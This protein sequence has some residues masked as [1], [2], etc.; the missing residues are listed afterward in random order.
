LLLLVACSESSKEQEPQDTEQGVP[1][2][3]Q[4][5]PDTEQG[6][7]DTQQDTGQKLPDTQDGDDLIVSTCG[8]NDRF[9]AFD[10]GAIV[11]TELMGMP[12]D[13]AIADNSS[14]LTADGQ[15]RIYFWAG[16]MDLEGTGCH[17]ILTSDGVEVILEDGIRVPSPYGHPKL[18]ALENGQ[19]RIF[20]LI[21][22]GLGSHY[23]NN[24]V[25]FTLEEG[26]RISSEQ[27]GLQRIGGM[28]VVQRPDG[29]FRGFFSNLGVPGQQPN[30]VVDQIKSA[31]SFDQLNWTMDGGVRIGEGAEPLNGKPRQPFALTRNGACVTLFYQRV[32]SPPTKLFYATA[33]DGFTFTQEYELEI[34]GWNNATA[35][36]NVQ[37]L[38]DGSYRL[39]FDAQSKELGNHIRSA[40]FELVQ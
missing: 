10:L 14:V 18:F 13:V 2:T 33:A 6:V 20:H 35:G 32:S 26:T 34:E 22:G 40:G 4:G 1:D 28:S 17:S 3:E 12:D 29:S 25:D 36:A 16:K 39:F 8:E 7:P 37:R 11:T 27:S 21:I 31:T 23:S 9:A 19:I 5:V 38:A 30:E 15:V 24:G